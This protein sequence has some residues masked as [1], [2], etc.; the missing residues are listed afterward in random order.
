MTDHGMSGKL[1]MIV[2][3]T[4]NSITRFDKKVWLS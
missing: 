1:T 2:N 3:V 4:A